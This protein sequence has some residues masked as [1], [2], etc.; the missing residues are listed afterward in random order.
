MSIWSNPAVARAAQ[1]ILTSENYVNAASADKFPRPKHGADIFVED[2]APQTWDAYK[3]QAKAKAILRMAITSAKF[4]KTRLDHAM[5]ATGLPGV[6]KT[7]LAR[8]VANEMGV[9]LTETQGAVTPDEA[10]GIMR[11]LSDGDIWFIDEAH[12][13]VQGGKGKAEWLLAFLQ[14]GVMLSSDG[15]QEV[16]D[17]TIIAATTDSQMLPET[18]L[19]RFPVRPIIESYS[20]AEAAEIAQGM[21]DRVFTSIGLSAPTE[22]TCVKITQAANNSP[23]I[24]KSILTTLRDAE[25]SNLADRDANGDH[26]LS[27]TLDLIGVTHDGLDTMAQAYLTALVLMCEGTGSIANIMQHMQESTPPMQTEKLLMTKGYVQIS[28]TGRTATEDGMARTH[29]ILRERGL[30]S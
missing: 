7:T 5:I 18:I 16:P 24:M 22:N 3:G 19:Q 4:R 28:R 12:Q 25:I 27:T 15:P 1:R 10:I 14:D 13:L 11:N 26:D 21:S 6:G 9:G 17:I 23:R 2:G 29:E 30:I 8:I 20:P